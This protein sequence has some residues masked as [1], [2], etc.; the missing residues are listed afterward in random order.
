MINLFRIQCQWT[1][2]LGY[3]GCQRLFMRS[4]PVSVKFMTA[5][6]AWR[7]SV[8]RRQSMPP[9]PRKISGAKVGNSIQSL[10][11]FNSSLQLVPLL[12]KWRSTVKGMLKISW[13]SN[14]VEFPSLNLV[15]IYSG[16]AYCSE[17]SWRTGSPYLGVRMFLWL[18]YGLS[19]SLWTLLWRINPTGD[20]EVC[21]RLN[22]GCLGH[23]RRGKQCLPTKTSYSPSPLSP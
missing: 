12:K 19:K 8:G 11:C 23:R 18:P 13:F 10:Y 17:R 4:F 22:C 20:H 15:N 5:T 16:G 7:R 14:T 21:W 2:G 3:L 9:R 1:R 6:F